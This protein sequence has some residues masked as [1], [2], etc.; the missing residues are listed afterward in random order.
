MPG[1][2]VILPDS[3]SATWNAV[4]DDIS[5][6][7]FSAAYGLQFDSVDE[8]HTFIADSCQF[9]L[10][11][12]CDLEVIACDFAHI[13]PHVLPPSLATC[14][15]FLL[16]ERMEHILGVSASAY[17]RSKTVRAMLR[18]PGMPQP[19]PAE[20]SLQDRERAYT[21]YCLIHRDRVQ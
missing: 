2:R 18:I 13:C 21:T 6:F 15:V 4:A 12:A 9:D 17:L 14:V 19:I 16:S 5:D 20:T 11:V 1:Q 3:L 8:C 10:G 7:D